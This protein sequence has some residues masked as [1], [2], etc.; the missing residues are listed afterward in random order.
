MKCMTYRVLFVYASRKIFGE[1][2]FQY[3]F[4]NFVSQFDSIR[5]YLLTFFL[6]FLYY[7]KDYEEEEKWPSPSPSM[8][9]GS[10]NGKRVDRDEDL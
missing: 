1:F 4:A 9:S 5:G 6:F 7:F 10:T 8:P 3:L 2:L